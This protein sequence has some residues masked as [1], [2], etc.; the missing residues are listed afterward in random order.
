MDTFKNKSKAYTTIVVIIF[1]VAIALRL[2]LSLINPGG[3]DDH[4]Q[5]CRIIVNTGCLPVQEDCAECFNAKLFHVLVA[6]G[7]KFCHLTDEKT[8]TRLA[9]LISCFA[10]VLTIVLCYYFLDSRPLRGRV[11][12]W[13]FSMVALNPGLI[14]I[15]AKATN[16]SLAI[17]FG[18]C[19]IYFAYQFFC[20]GSFWRFWGI[21]IFSILAGL[22]KGTTIVL[23]P[24]IIIML[25]L[26]V[27]TSHGTILDKIKHR[28]NRYAMIL[29]ILFLA[30]VPLGGQYVRL[31]S[32]HVVSVFPKKQ[33]KYPLPNFFKKTYYGR[34]GI[35]SVA[36]SYLT[37]RFVDMLKHPTITNG[38]DVYPLHRTSFWSQLY[39]RVNFIYFA[40]FPANWETKDFVL[41][42]LGRAILF[43][44]LIPTGLFLWGFLKEMGRWGIAA[45]RFNFGFISISNEWVFLFFAATQITFLLY[46]TAIYRDFC[47]IKDIFL[48]PS[49]LAATYIFTVGLSSFYKAL[50]KTFWRVVLELVFVILVVLYSLSVLSLIMKLLKHN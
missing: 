25:V 22:T 46:G 11:K 19:T 47:F 39:G 35:T 10:G 12:L 43:L 50:D 41:L 17:L 34:P 38:R 6:I 31:R 45:V 18:T 44:A 2:A 5:V 24:T 42:N 23:F 32:H 29:C 1:V 37:F 20:K 16:D 33:E 30:I 36:N 49:L 21:T 48:F 13:V 27:L 15:N 7:I 26:K 9:Q 40:S 14:A 4:M 3:K 28:Y 8:Q